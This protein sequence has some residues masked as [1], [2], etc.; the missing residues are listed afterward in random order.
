MSEKRPDNEAECIEHMMRCI[1]GGRQG[2][3]EAIRVASIYMTHHGDFQ[4]AAAWFQLALAYILLNKPRAFN[5]CWQA[6]KVAEGYND[7]MKGDFHRDVAQYYVRHNK[8]D[9]ARDSLAFARRFH[10]G[11]PNKLA[12]DRLVEGKLYLGQ[13]DVTNALQVFNGV[14]RKL[15]NLKD[16]NQQYLRNAQWWRLLA[17]A[18]GGFQYRHAYRALYEAAFGPKSATAWRVDEPS[19]YRRRLAMVLYWAGPARGP[20]A[21]A[22]L[23]VAA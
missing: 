12:A 2:R 4:T 7:P 9:L 23:R 6:A 16:C 21:R 10:K 1:N 17:S 19:A 11:H 13:Q 14:A 20:I 15:R 18:A 8:P 5:D 22:I 3:K